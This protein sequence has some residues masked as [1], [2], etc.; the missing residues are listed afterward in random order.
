MQTQVQSDLCSNRLLKSIVQS[1]KAKHSKAQ[2]NYYN[3]MGESSKF[4]K[5]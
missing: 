3:N 1:I 2:L 4:P 5:S